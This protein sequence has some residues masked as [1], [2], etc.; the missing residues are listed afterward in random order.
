MIRAVPF[1]LFAMLTCAQAANEHPGYGVVESVKALPPGE[2]AS[3][4]ASAPRRAGGR[5]LAGGTYLVRVR[6][7]DGSI[8][9]RSQKGRD[10]KAGDRVLLTNA[11]DVVKDWK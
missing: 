2:S 4:G 7:D 3:A 6:M 8:Q 1:F 11:G 10:F 9:V 5:P